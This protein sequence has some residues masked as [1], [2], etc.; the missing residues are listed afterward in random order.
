MKGYSVDSWI[1]RLNIV[2]MSFLP[3]LTSRSNAT[4]I[5]IPASY[6]VNTKK[7]IIKFIHKGRSPRIANTTLKKNKVGGLT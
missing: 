3:H 7:M 2:M 6:F 5:K 1:G 4:A